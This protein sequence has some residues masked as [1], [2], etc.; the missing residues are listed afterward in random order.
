MR[1]IRKAMIGLAAFA[2]LPLAAQGPV[3]APAVKKTEAA[4]PAAKTQAA[5]APLDPKDLEAWMDGYLPYALER[6]RIPGAVVVVVRG[7]E[8]V[9]QKGYG[10]SDVAKRAPVLPETTLFRPGSVSKLFTWTA[11][12]Q[13]VEAGKIDLDK[14]VNA[15][16]DFKIPPYDGKPITMRNIMT[17]TAGFEESIRHLISSDPKA[18]MTLKKQMPLALPERVFA[19]GTT[20]A[21]SNYATALAGYIVERV[22]GEDFD[23]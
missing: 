4:V 22:S 1:F 7:G 20:P 18:V 11:V 15:Y 5:P 19:P 14:D 23:T 8:V 21:Y 16:L 2:A 17:H 6:G 12:M 13:Q 9:L 3:P 10:Y